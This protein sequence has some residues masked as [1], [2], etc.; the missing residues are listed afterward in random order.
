MTT[1]NR[2][3]RGRSFWLIVVVAMQ[4]LFLTGIVL[5]HYSALWVGKEIRLETA[6]VD[7]RDQLYGDYVQLNYKINNADWSKWKAEGRKAERG[8][9]VYVLLQESGASGLYE[10]QGVYRSKPSHDADE[11]VLKGRVQYVTD[12]TIRIHYGFEQY[13][14]SENTGKSLEERARSGDLVVDV[15]AAPWGSAAIER[16]EP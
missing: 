1:N 11:A 8:D 2:S 5:Y 7:P 12:E 16:I 14:V 15:K 9:N 4:L 6:P 3:K 13:Y 10:M